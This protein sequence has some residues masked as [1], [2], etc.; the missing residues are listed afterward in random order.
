M[1]PPRGWWTRP[2]RT[3]RRSISAGSGWRRWS[4]DPPVRGRA[5][6][7]GAADVV[8]DAEEEAKAAV[9][10]E[11]KE[12]RLAEKAKKIQAMLEAKRAF[13]AKVAEKRKAL[14]ALDA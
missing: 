10:A 6:S 5:C 12:K 11:A 7:S 2:Q 13:E 8:L 9:A 3:A 1:W 14:D 4:A